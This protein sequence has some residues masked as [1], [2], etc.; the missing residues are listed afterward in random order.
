M[1]FNILAKYDVVILGSGISGLLCALELSKQDKTVCILTKEAVTESSSQYAQGGIAVPLD[2]SD[3]IE[4][5]LNDTLKAGVGLSNVTVAREI[6]SNSISALEKLISYGVSFDLSKDNKIHQGKEAA[7][8]KPR[9]CHVGGDSTGRF[10]TKALID[11][12][13][14]EPRI[15]ISQGTIALH[16]FKDEYLGSIGILVEDIT[17]DRYVVFAKDVI[18]ATGGIGQL[19]DT[20]TN[21]LVSSGDGITMAYRFGAR[22]QDVEMIQFHP[23]VFLESGEP[24]LI[25]EA[26]RGEG[27]KLKNMHGDYFALNY[28]KMAELAPR[29]VLARAIFSELQKTKSKHVYLDLSSFDQTYFA[30]RF[31]T[32]YKL[33]CKYRIDLFNKGIPVAP[34]AHYFIGGIKCDISGKTNIA[35]LWTIGEASSNGFHG[36]NR[37]ASNS[38]LECIVIPHFL[39]KNLLEIRENIKFPSDE[40]IDINLDETNYDDEIK[41]TIK[42]LQIKNT[43]SLGLVRSA[44]S[45]NQH[46]NWLNEISDKFKTNLSSTSYQAQELKN[47]ILLS[48]LICQA[49]I[50]RKHSIGVHF[51]ED[52]QTPPLEPVHSVFYINKQLF[53]EAETSQRQLVSFLG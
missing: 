37:L 39:T 49:S 16:I 29:D 42:E 17:R 12:A 38:L 13:C 47:M 51:R 6:I 21:P 24:F 34:A 3:S 11:K 22:L 40:Y 10:V 2:K 4:E 25:T 41:V 18:V 36:A 44:L 31:P 20:T 23:T 14:R 8:S 26:I 27:G 33:C 15:S 52:F 48:S 53:W 28:H 7:H 19:Y 35:G 32:I 46:L 45:L 9:I 30:N 1:R 5:H 50:E 43:Q